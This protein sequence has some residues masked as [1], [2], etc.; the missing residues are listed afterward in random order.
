MRTPTPFGDAI[1]QLRKACGKSL[2][3]LADF[4]GC[5]IVHMSDIERGKKNPPSADRI[6][7][8]LEC[9][10]AAEKLDEMLVLAAQARRSIEIAV[11]GKGGEA[12][13][14]LIALQRRC[15]E[16]NLDEETARQIRKL[17]EGGSGK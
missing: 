4:I 1:R 3:Q 5:S 9:L 6:L 13:H 8:L 12:T 11:E 14:M 7:A 10:G 16:D 15:D 17:L 2:G